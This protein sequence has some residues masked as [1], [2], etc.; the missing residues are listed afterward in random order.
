MLLYSTDLDGLSLNTL[1]A[2]CTPQQVV[3]GGGKLPGTEP[4]GALLAI[5]DAD[6]GVFGAWVGEGIHLSHGRYYGGGDS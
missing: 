3:G 6:G 1:Y 2:R 4:S 5:Q